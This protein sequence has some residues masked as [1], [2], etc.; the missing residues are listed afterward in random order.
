MK[1]NV[2]ELYDIIP[3]VKD[4]GVECLVYHPVIVAQED[5]QNTSPN[6]RFWLDAG[7]SKS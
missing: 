1:E 2:R 4:L 7:I 5:M 6:A 3:L